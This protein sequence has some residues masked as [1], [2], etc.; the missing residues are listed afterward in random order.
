MLQVLS[1]KRIYFA[2]EIISPSEREHFNPNQATKSYMIKDMK[3]IFTLLVLALVSFASLS[4]QDIPA[5]TWG[6]T[7]PLHVEGKYLC[8]PYGN[9]VVLHGVM[10]TPSPY[11]NNNRWKGPGWGEQF[12]TTHAKNAIA[13]FDQLFTALTD[14]AHGAYANVF[15]LHLDPCWTNYNSTK[16]SG[17]T[18]KDGKV[19][20]PHG[21]EVG[22][23]ANIYHFNKKRLE[24][25][26]KVLYFPI[27]KSAIDHGLYVIMRPPGVFPGYVE[28][29][30]YYN[31]YIMTV[32][33]IVSKND[34]IKKYSGQIS[35]E[36]GNE[37]VTL[38]AKGGASSER[39]LC[40]FFQ[41]VVDKI[42]ENGFDG[43]VWGVGTGWQGNCRDYG[44]FPLVGTNLGYAVHNYVGWYGGNDRTYSTSDKEK[45]ANE[46]HASHP[47]MDTNPI[48]ITE[49][50]W[51]PEK[52]G[53]GHY[54][55]HGDWVL[56]N[57]GTWATGSTSKWGA[58]Y[59]YMMDKYDNVSMTLSGTACYIDIDDYL[60][61]NTLTPAFKTAMEANGLDPWEGSGVSCFAW[62]KEWAKENYARPDLSKPSDDPGLA[63]DKLEIGSASAKI[64][65][66]QVA[67]F[68]LKGTFANGMTSNIPTSLCTFSSSDSEVCG[69]KDGSLV[70]FSEGEASVT[71]TYTSPAGN[72]VE[73]T[74]AVEVLPMFTFDA[75]I[76]NPSIM[77]SGSYT[78]RT[79]ALLTGRNGLGGWEFDAGVDLSAYNYLVCNIRRAM[80]PTPTLRIYDSSDAWSDDYCEVEFTKTNATIDLHNAVK[81][82]GKPLDTTNI[83]IVAVKTLG[84]TTLYFSDIFL[85]MDGETDATG[86]HSAKGE[87]A[88]IAEDIYNVSGQRISSFERGVNIVRQTL[89]DGT[90]ISTKVFIK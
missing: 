54:N 2:L 89:S 11:F 53:T 67:D 25:F 52:E 65:V 33:D 88:V 29:G 8:D 48:V 69:D 77:Q 3:K 75:Q 1:Q 10:D 34:S 50:D 81:A 46:F 26:L 90:R 21:N 87:A 15:R 13:Y 86:I 9:H 12:N 22:G 79:R 68:G 35:I 74:F 16:A 82:N 56:S 19:Y 39:A 60:Y 72:S 5:S 37:P 43:I 30:D 28:V 4:A 32:W 45:Y 62:Y 61:R 31:D 59:K 14:T 58:A 78:E 83:K 18:E 38:K 51:S 44:K 57:Y 85:S 55:E 24:S 76:F 7:P 23:E 49:V 80:S 71:A 73:N 84:G 63:I 27:A 40:D 17:F 64:M 70:G 42:R 36:L 66:G 20:D 41:P 6:N 47:I